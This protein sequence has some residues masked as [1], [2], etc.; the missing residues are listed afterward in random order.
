MDRYRASDFIRIGLVIA[1]IVLVVLSYR[2]REFVSDEERA[3]WD[4][5]AFF[6]A[7]L[8]TVSQ[9]HLEDDVRVRHNFRANYEWFRDVFLP[10]L[11]GMPEHPWTSCP[12]YCIPAAEKLTQGNAEMESSVQS[13]LAESQSRQETR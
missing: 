8:L 1:I 11:R 13:A 6:L 7:G 10:H 2:N 3:T 4:A 9:S 5:T 12:E